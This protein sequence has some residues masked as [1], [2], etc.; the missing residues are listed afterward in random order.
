MAR[1]PGDRSALFSSR[2][3]GW[4]ETR[5]RRLKFVASPP[6]PFL[7]RISRSQVL[8]A[9]LGFS[10]VSIHSA[11][12]ELEPRAY[13]PSPI[14]FNIAV[15]G[16]AF[17]SGDL[18]FDPAGP[19]TDADAEIFGAVFAYVRTLGIAGRSASLG[20]SVPYV[21]GE[22]R[23][24]VL[25]EYREASRSEFGDPKFRA[26]INLYGAP[27]MT[28]KEFAAYQPKWNVGASFTISAPLGGY[29]SD[30]LVNVGTNRW[31]FK[32]ELGISRAVGRWTFE[33]QT[34]IWLYTDND[35]YY[36]GRTRSQEP[37]GSA[38]FHVIYTIRPRMWIAYNA[39]YYRGGRTSFGEGK[40]LDLLS[41]S[42]MGLTF[43]M[44]VSKQQSL[45]FSYSRGA[46]T[47][48]GADFDSV[49]VAW[50]YVW[51]KP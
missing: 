16:L 21:V 47:T 49:A 8:V 15:T 31:G 30:K 17:N 20:L 38:Q 33:L 41:N 6:F 34:G 19:I 3:F 14:N 24:T 27:A 45:K 2:L 51:G 37:I 35:D 32:P 4:G 36:G 7:F 42:R 25:D 22:V 5:L 50:Q 1:K 39:N 28:A 13:S 46:F 18:A 23:G 12:Q 26:A 43:A 10:S 29:S 11:G 48:I 40:N 44:P 9:I